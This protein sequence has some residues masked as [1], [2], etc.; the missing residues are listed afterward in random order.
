M[1]SMRG[2]RPPCT[3]RT[4]P[5]PRPVV[6]GGGAVGEDGGL[7]SWERDWEFSMLLLFIVGLL[8]AFRAVREKRLMI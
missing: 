2:E 4:A 8:E 5:L 7:E 6:W 1:L 3:Q